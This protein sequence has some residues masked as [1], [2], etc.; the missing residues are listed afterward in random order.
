MMIGSLV[1]VL[2]AKLKKLA[3]NQQQANNL[4]R[5]FDYVAANVS[6]EEMDHVQDKCGF[7]LRW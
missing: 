6:S 4:L 3:E 1:Y 2:G 5:Q 7:S